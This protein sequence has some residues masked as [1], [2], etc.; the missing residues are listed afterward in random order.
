MSVLAGSAALC[1]V[2]AVAPAIPAQASEVLITA[3]EASLPPA[4]GAFSV[5][6]RGITRGPRIDYVADPSGGMHSPIRLQMKFESFGGATIDPASLKVTY[7][8]DPAV[9]LTDRVKPFVKPT[10]IDMPD[11]VLPPGDHTLRVDV[12]DSDGRVA[13][14]SIVLKIAP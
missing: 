6:T 9:D 7:L 8:K 4:K 14:S 13:T 2:A 12:K 5:A 3:Q 1:A 10:G 11:A